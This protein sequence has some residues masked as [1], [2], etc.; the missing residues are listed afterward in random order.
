MA[1]ELHQFIVSNFCRAA[2]YREV[3]V[4]RLKFSHYFGY[5]EYTVVL[6][7]FA[8][9]PKPL[10]IGSEILDLPRFLTIIAGRFSFII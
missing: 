3:H 4:G 10:P 6:F 2:T 1:V 9:T 7:T 8:S 5:P